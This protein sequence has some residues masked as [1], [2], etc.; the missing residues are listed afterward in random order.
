M[1]PRVLVTGVTGYVGGRLLEALEARG[2]AIRCIARRPEFLRARVGRHTEVMAADCLDEASLGPALDGID[3]A[4]YLVHSMGSGADFEALESRAAANF[5][6]AAGI[7]GTNGR[8][9]QGSCA[10]LAKG[11]VL[12]DVRAAMRGKARTTSDWRRHGRRD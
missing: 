2:Y 10:P 3:T 4:F 6:R 9:G 5:A 7:L 1:R 8:L 11:R 12:P